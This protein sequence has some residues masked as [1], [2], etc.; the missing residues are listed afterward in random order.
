MARQRRRS[1]NG[2]GTITH[3]QDG[4]YQG[5]AYVETASGIRKRVSVYGRTWEEAHRNLI[6][7]QSQ[8][9]RGV[10]LPDT[11]STL[12]EYLAYWLAEEIAPHRRPKTYQGY[13]S[14]VRVHLV[15]GL[16]NKR[17]RELRAQEV[18]VWL[19]RVREECQC[20]KHGWDANRLPP[21][22]CDAGQCCEHKL[23]AR[24]V[25]SIHAVLRNA[26]EHAVREELI[27]RNV[28]K[29]V[30]SPAPSYRTGK[31]LSP[32]QAKL[33]LKELRDHRLYA[34]Y[35]LALLLGMRR[36]ELLGLRWS[37]VDLEKGTLTVVTNLQRVSGELRLV[38]PKTR[39]S[40]RTIP[41]P[42]LAVVA[43]R[44]HQER[45]AQERVT[46]G[47]GWKENGLVFPSRL[48]TPFE[49]DNLRRSWDPVR[50][51][52]GLDLRFHDLRHTCITLLLDLGTPVHIVQ[53]IA[54]HSDHGVTMQVYAHASLDEQRKALGRLEGTLL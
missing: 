33:V 40:E 1:P 48:G 30:K 49:P 42:A 13:E 22:C 5:R 31:G 17:I 7:L 4:R 10:P 39:S 46:A 19:N 38:L 29:L 14:V 36:G 47:S 12:G 25:Q 18:R 50:K 2:A 16:G 54:G 35:V 37:A 34:L 6:D 20:C 45:Q 51:R 44:E 23:S 15:P 43:L 28:A 24:M 21:R 52:L 9:Q 41:L 32:V 27:T 8:E 11:D 3:R 53:Q 26:L